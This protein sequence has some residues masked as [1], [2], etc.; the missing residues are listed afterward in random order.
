VSPNPRMSDQG[1]RA[2]RL[3]ELG[4]VE[5][6]GPDEIDATRLADAVTRVMARPSPAHQIALDGAERTRR[7]IDSWT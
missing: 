6:L 4:L 1:V 2:K 3:A 5:L 7:W